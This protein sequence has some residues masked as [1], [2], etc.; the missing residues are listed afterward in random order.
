MSFDE[1]KQNIELAIQQGNLD[2]AAN[3]LKDVEKDLEYDSDF[4][5]LQTVYYYYIGDF[6]QAEVSAKKGLMI[7]PFHFELNFNLYQIHLELENYVDALKSYFDAYLIKS[8]DKENLIEMNLNETIKIVGDKINSLNKPIEIKQNMIAEANELIASFLEEVDKANYKQFPLK[9]VAKNQFYYHDWIKMNG[10]QYFAASYDNLFY[11]N[12]P[13]TI[14]SYVCKTEIYEAEEKNELVGGYEGKRTFLPIIN[15]HD[16]AKLQIK[17][18]TEKKVN[19]K[20]NKAQEYEYFVLE[21]KYKITSDEL[22]VFGK[23]IVLQKDE[24]KKD[25]VITI[26]IDGLS[27]DYIEKEGL[28]N[29]MPFTAK[30]FENGFNCKNVHATAEWTLPSVATICTGL[31][32]VNHGVY[33]PERKVGLPED[34]QTLFEMIKEKG[35]MTAK[36]DGDW[37]VT[38]TYGYLRGVDRTIYQAN[39]EA[40]DVI[41]EAMKHL[42]VFKDTNQYLWLGFMDLH[43]VADKIKGSI[44]QQINIPNEYKATKIQEVE[45]SVRLK[46]DE[47]KIAE[48]KSA[49]KQVDRYLGILY[50]YLQDEYQDKEILITLISDHGQT[51][52]SKDADRILVDER[53]R[54][55]LM[56]KGYKQGESQE[57][58]GLTDYLPIIASFL[59][60]EAVNHKIDGILP[61]CFGGE[62][63]REYVYSEKIFPGQEYEV[64]I[65]SKEHVIGF[66]TREKVKSD[67][68]V[69][70]KDAQ[71]SVMNRMG[72]ETVCDKQ[73]YIKIIEEHMKKNR[74]YK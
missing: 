19:I 73:Y 57:L 11:L 71:I 24:G 47:N 70:L 28:K 27:Y 3:M 12:M 25:L 2:E 10:K 9:S 18:D 32:T 74:V 58:I 48:Y 56:I 17:T 39:M 40:K 55:P 63:E 29:I 44:V 72:E 14:K 34:K 46:Y 1:I 36:I 37:R 69:A 68:R 31:H 26:F 61:V 35:Y 13:K 65:N 67:G 22:I 8:L 20:M 7:T 53:T 41:D 33:H 64:C 60:D 45:K 21:G 4:Y 16:C 50:N 54:V 38:P 6:K 5:S 66:K 23:P 52:L 43:K 42:E 51:Y 30:Y 62:K 59:G 15:R 49:I